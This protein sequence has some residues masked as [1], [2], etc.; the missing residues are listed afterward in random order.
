MYGS[1]DAPE[2]GRRA[3]LVQYSLPRYRI[4]FYDKVRSRL[5]E[6]GIAFDLVY[7]QPSGADTAKR[8]TGTI[9]WAKSI[10]N[11]VL[12]V[13]RKELSWQPCL[14]YLRGADLVIVEQASRLLL[15]YVL[16]AG[17]RL[18]GP[19]V[20]F[21]GHGRN[22]KDH[23]VSRVGET[24]KRVVS[25]RPHWWFAY[26]DLS[27]RIVRDLGFPTDRITAVQNTIDAT[28]LREQRARVT[29]AQ[30]DDLRRQ[31]HLTGTNVG[32]FTGG[33]YA[34]KR[35][36]FL[37]A[38][39]HEIRA[40]IPDFELIIIGAGPEETVIAGAARR[41]AWIH[42]VGPVFDEEKVPYFALAR[43]ALMPG[44]VGLA[45]VDSFALEVPMVAVDLP[46]HS[47]E[48]D[49][50]V[51]GHNG[52]MLARG[53][54]PSEYAES[55]A[56]LLSDDALMEKLRAGCR[57]SAET[58]TIEEMVDRFVGGIRQAIA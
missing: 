7:G 17:Q 41:E 57:A 30:L 24:V 49:Y 32:V 40:R 35:L 58:Y 45:V 26:N 3:V 15:N 11:R 52:I 38:A 21:E 9:P 50:L 4:P 8:D 12:R 23:A 25:R 2:Q 29:G 46:F 18:G 55:V 47:P 27:A 56:E 22:L 54:T 6:E 34:E 42:W 51:D 1:S 53:T 31:L 19:K 28:A 43:V 10:N 13:G 16:L 36:E 44:L 20:A 48:I 37:I 33:L 5:A 14:R 39:A